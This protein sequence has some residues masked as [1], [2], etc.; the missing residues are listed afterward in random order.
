MLK[1]RHRHA[2]WHERDARHSADFKRSR[3]R[4][5]GNS[6]RRRCQR[7]RRERTG[8]RS[9]RRTSSRQARL[10]SGGKRG[11]TAK[12][13]RLHARVCYCLHVRLPTPTTLLLLLLCVCG[14][15]SGCGSSG[16]CLTPCGE[17]L[18][19]RELGVARF[20][21]LLQLRLG[22]LGAKAHLNSTRGVV[23]Q[24]HATGQKATRTLLMVVGNKTNCH[25]HP[26]LA[27]P[28]APPPQQQPPRQPHVR[29]RRAVLPAHTL[30]SHKAHSITTDVHGRHCRCVQARCQLAL[31]DQRRHRHCS[32]P[33]Q[34]V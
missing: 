21:M 5:K 12:L 3:E 17:A 14:S 22:L 26:L 32:C 13:E 11:T 20:A 10:T 19:K 25:P 30:R 24:V 31:P 15:G 9:R 29:Q 4:S 18:L 1:R 27:P 28:P 23:P 33:S 6:G 8:S 34:P 2:D 16:R 7:T